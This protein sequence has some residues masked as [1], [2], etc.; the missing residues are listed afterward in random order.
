MVL[1]FRNLSREQ[2][3]KVSALLWGF[4]RDAIDLEKGGKEIVAGLLV[5][6][7]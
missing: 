5:Q 2:M 4:K 1:K 6:D 7:I 3:Y